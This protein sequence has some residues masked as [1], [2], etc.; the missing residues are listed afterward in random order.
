MNREIKPMSA[1][2]YFVATPIGTADDITLRAL[3]TLNS[4]DV[5][6]AEDTR[7]TR[8]L[9]DIHG[10]ALRDRPLI[11]YHDHN[12][13]KVRPRLLGFIAQGK[14]VAYAS[15]AGTP[16]V[17]D[18]GYVLAR[19]A[20]AAGYPVTSVPGASAVLSALTLSGLPTD[21][22]MF[23]GFAPNAKGARRSFLRELRDIPA[24]LVFFESPK[25][26]QAFLTD[27]VQELGE[28]RPMALCREL[29]KRFEEARR[30]TIGQVL[31]TTCDRPV[32]GEVVL[33]VGGPVKRELSEDEIREHLMQAM[34]TL[35]VKDAAAQISTQLGV[36]RRT[37]YQL[38]L[39][40]ESDE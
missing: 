13:P 21:R 27:C 18:P 30:G 38:A 10:I 7:N 15:D 2:L 1:G 23:V 36:P 28:D 29:T 40:I 24:T 25:R 12:G 16:L 35:S 4:V 3:D 32:K 8:R 17:A 9:M 11:A 31:Q 39:K 5:I 6:A 34:E 26:V 14:S 19:D 22:F 33:V 20:I 37:A